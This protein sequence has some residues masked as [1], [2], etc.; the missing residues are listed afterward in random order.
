MGLNDKRKIK[1]EREKER[2][3]ERE[4]ERQR[5]RERYRN[6]DLKILF[7][8]LLI[9]KKVDVTQSHGLISFT[10]ELAERESQAKRRA[11]FKLKFNS[12]YQTTIVQG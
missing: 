8:R 1:R 9:G 7:E 4:K 6:C 11:L 12:R 3:R 2:K 10:V 5:D